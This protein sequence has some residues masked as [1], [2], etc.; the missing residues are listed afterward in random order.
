MIKLFL[1]FVFT[2]I[3]SCSEFSSSYER[4]ENDRIRLLDFMYEPAEAA[5][6]DTVL[7]K[8]LFAGKEITSDD[9]SWRAS[10]KVAM[11]SNGADT[12]FDE[13]PLDCTIQPYNFS[14]R[15]SCV[16]LRFVIPKNCILESPAIADDW[17]ASLPQQLRATLPEEIANL[18]RTELISMVDSLSTIISKADAQEQELLVSLLPVDIA[19]ALPLFMQLLT[20]K[21]RLY[22]DVSRSHRIKSDYSVSFAPRIEKV[23]GIS[24]TRNHN[25]Q[26]DS[27]GLYIVKGS[28]LTRLDRTGD[29]T[30]YVTLSRGNDSAITIERK[31]GCTYFLEAFVHNRDSVR[32]LYDIVKN[33]PASTE[34]LTAEWFFELKESESEN[35]KVNDMM[36]VFPV[37]DLTAVLY[38]PLDTAISHFTIWVQ[39]TD[40]KM[41][42]YNRSQGST[43]FEF[44]GTFTY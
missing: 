23:P 12:A 9:I 34:E 44:N 29:G 38:L 27:I 37:N 35:V 16:A 13:E 21:I 2:G 40:S 7:V 17:V 5:P 32:T 20:V 19:A 39:V 25:P 15:T 4:I 33:E 31:K 26:V 8:A 43:V 14:E 41:N 6:G 42:V 10:F 22:A 3:I 24:I 36:N 11:N 1:L 30:E 28:N 18:S